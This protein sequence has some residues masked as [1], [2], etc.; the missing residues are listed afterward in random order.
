MHWEPSLAPELPENLPGEQVMQDP[1]VCPTDGLKDPA[2]HRLQLLREVSAGKLLNV[3]LGHGV[4]K[5]APGVL[6]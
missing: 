4:Q 6:A 1:E 5:E 2:G 3:P